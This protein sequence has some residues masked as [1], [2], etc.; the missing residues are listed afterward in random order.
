MAGKPKTMSHI[1]QVLQHYQQGAKIKAIA[2][3]VGISKNTIK[4]YLSK[5]NA[6]GWPM[7]F[8]P[9]ANIKRI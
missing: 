6:A 1:K 2:R 8:C 3:I 9:T 7:N 4:D 5:I